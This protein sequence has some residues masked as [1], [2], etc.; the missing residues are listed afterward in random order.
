MRNFTAVPNALVRGEI[1]H[2]DGQRVSLGAQALYTLILDYSRGG[3]RP[4]TASQQRLGQQLS[5]TTRTVR[6]WLRELEAL[7]LVRC[8]R[9]GRTVT[10]TTLPLLLPERTPPSDHDRTPVSGKEDEGEEDNSSST[11]GNK[12][13]VPLCS[14][15]AC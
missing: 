5:T 7:E 2:P 4:C 3:K 12:V 9:E 8:H 14:G 13:T 1:R 11:Q 10:N 6:K 15:R